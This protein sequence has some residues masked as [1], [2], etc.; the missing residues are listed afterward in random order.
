MIKIKLK[1][2]NLTTF[3]S[4]IYFIISLLL[5]LFVSLRLVR[6]YQLKGDYYLNLLLLS[7]FLAIFLFF[8]IFFKKKI[9]DLVVIIITSSLLGIYSAEIYIN[10]KHFLAYKKVS[11]SKFKTFKD[12][13]NDNTSIA[14]SGPISNE[15]FFTMGG[16]SY[17]TTILCNETGKWAIYQSD[18]YGFNNP[19]TEWDKNNIDYMIIGDSFAHGGCVDEGNDITSYLRKLS[20]KAAINLGF[21]GN[22]PLKNFAKLKEYINNLNPKKIY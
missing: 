6:D 22:G 15:P 19:D 3:V 1:K 8:V 13:K 21:I 20:G 14:Y 5:I 9:K 16:L 17:S 2:I 10:Y 18:R 12:L 7:I 11:N 4:I